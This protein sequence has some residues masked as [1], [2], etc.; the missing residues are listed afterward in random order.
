V[1]AW[2][3]PVLLQA[4]AWMDYLEATERVDTLRQAGAA[5]R[6]TSGLPA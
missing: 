2:P 1:D 4:L 6:R 5:A 3:L